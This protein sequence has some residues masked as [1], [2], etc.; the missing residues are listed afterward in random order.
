L[1][2][3]AWFNANPL[4]AY[5]RIPAMDFP[6]PS[7]EFLRLAAKDVDKTFRLVDSKLGLKPGVNS[8]FDQLFGPETKTTSDQTPHG[9][10]TSQS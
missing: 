2:V 3:G 5:H 10:D 4:H 6:S 7:M 9:N 8:T 1:V